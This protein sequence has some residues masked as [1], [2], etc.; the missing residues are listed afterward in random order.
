MAKSNN[1]LA[2]VSYSVAKGVRKNSATL[3]YVVT[4]VDKLSLQRQTYTFTRK[5][6]FYNVGRASEYL[7][8]SGMY[9]QG[10]IV[11]IVPALSILESRS[12]A[13]GDPTVIMNGKAQTLGDLR[14]WDNMTGGINVNEDRIDWNGRS[15][16]IIKVEPSEFWNDDPAKFKLILRE[17]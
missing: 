4:P 6:W 2:I 8:A 9:T 7:V 11:A 17:E 16:R 15:Y 3:R 14:P 1:P 12:V 10:D 13:I 5:V